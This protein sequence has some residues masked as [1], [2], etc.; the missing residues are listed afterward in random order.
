M[1]ERISVVFR[2]AAG[3]N[4]GD[5]SR[6]LSSIEAV[7][8]D[9][10]GGEISMHP[11]DCEAFR[12]MLGF[13]VTDLDAERV[14]VALNAMQDGDGRSVIDAE[15]EKIFYSSVIYSDCALPL[16]LSG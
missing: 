3:K 2:P 5:I 1:N 14:V 4:A 7:I 11:H 15:Q 10:G 12:F 8:S 16:S 9:A 6:F 13:A